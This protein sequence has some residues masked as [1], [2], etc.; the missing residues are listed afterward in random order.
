LTKVLSNNFP[1]QFLEP[2]HRQTT[3]KR[4]KYTLY[5][6]VC[7]FTHLAWLSAFEELRNPACRSVHS[8]HAYS[9]SM[10]IASVG[11]RGLFADSAW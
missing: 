2:T 4:K 11:R 9:I 10:L 1:F 7:W 5:K 6:V 8:T 3:P